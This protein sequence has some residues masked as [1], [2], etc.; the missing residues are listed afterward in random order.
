[1]KAMRAMTL[2]VILAVGLASCQTGS[3]TG[4]V[5]SE[6]VRQHPGTVVGAGAGAAGGAVVGG[7]AGGTKGA[8]IGGL[9]GGLAG[10][11]IGNYIERRD[12]APAAASTPVSTPPVTGQS[13][14]A[15]RSDDGMGLRMDRVQMSPSVV[16]PGGTVNLAATYTV[17]T[18]TDQWLAVRETREVRH[19]GEL[20]ANPTAQV[21]RT[22][23]TYT[24][25]LPITLPTT[26]ARGP[27]EVTTTV[28]LG[29]RRASQTTTFH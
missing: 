15:S 20:V 4:E 26:A 8:I 3:R 14:P 22:N 13:V 25:S 18:P 29:D 19:Q 2:I 7:L 6:T 16:P 17:Q 24:T 5:A 21:S 9:L 28:A 12:D 1:M 11:V 23:G 27:Y 10:G